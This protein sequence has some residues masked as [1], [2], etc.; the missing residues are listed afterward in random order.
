MI[1]IPVRNVAQALQAGMR[2]ILQTGVDEASRDGPVR[3][4]PVPVTTMF[5]RPTERVLHHARRNANPFFHL[6]ESMWMLAGRDDAE[7]LDRYVTDFGRRYAEHDGRIH[8]AYG[9]RWRGHFLAPAVDLFVSRGLDQIEQVLL[10]LASSPNSRQAVLS[11]WDPE[12]DLGLTAVRD[13]PC[14]THVYLRGQ[15]RDREGMLLHM[16]V[17][18]RSN[19]IVMGAYGA[20]A[21]HFSVLQ[22]YLAARLGWS[23]GTYWQISNNWHAYERDISRLSNCDWWSPESADDR[24]SAGL[25]KA[26]PLFRHETSGIV[27]QELDGWLSS[28]T[29]LMGNQNP[30]LFDM[31]LVPMA[32]AHEL[33]LQRRWDEALATCAHV[34]HTD[35][36][37]AA[38]EWIQRRQ[39]RAAERAA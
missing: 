16:T 24:Y 29:E 25:V 32:Q 17:C 8:G 37:V 39:V 18:C 2:R 4:A 6:F 26:Q 21:V 12:V 35:W 28:P 36:Q 1:V 30:Q 11:M 13:R 38:S 22:E 34:A 5:R 7:F 15:Q 23:V 10:V 27:L 9:R 14:N 3:V 33:A 19:D 20:N 31:L